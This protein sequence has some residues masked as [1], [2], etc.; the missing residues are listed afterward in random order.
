MK[1]GNKRQNTATRDPDRTRRR[2]LAA[3]L[4]EFSAHGFAGARVDTIARRARGNKRM[5][6]HYFG[7]KEAL[8]TAVLRF[9]MAERQAWAEAMSDDPA[10]RLPFWFKA[11]CEDPNWIRLLEWEALQ[12]NGTKLIDEKERR[13]SSLVWLNRL[14]QRQKKGKLTKQFNR[15][16]LALAMQSLTLFP[17]AFPQLAR[18]ITGKPVNNPKFRAEYG[19]FLKG[20]AAAFKPASRSSK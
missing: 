16:H 5:L 19:Q 14:E 6:Y 9:K 15:A 8:F 12:A 20:F 11:A 2:I 18:L 1:Q 13:D 7:N 10:E 4:A 3:A 17:S